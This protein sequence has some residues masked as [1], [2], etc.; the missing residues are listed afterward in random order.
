MDAA[1]FGLIVA[2][3]IAE[4]FDLR[5]PPRAGGLAIL[6]S[7]TLTTG[8]NVSNT[9]VA[10]AKL[11]AKV[12]AAGMVGDDVLGRAVVE[13]LKSA[14]LDTSAIFVSQ[15]AQT[16]A[17]VVA[18]EPGGERCFFHTPGVTPQL[19]LDVFRKCFPIFGKCAWMQVGYFGLLPGLT[20]DLAEA[21]KEFKSISPGTK[22]A[23]DT[24]N[25]PA[26][27]KLLWPI[28]PHL[29]LFAPSRTEAAALTGESDP[30]KMVAAFRP[31]MPQGVIG[32]KLD[33]EGCYLDNGEEAV[34]APAY[35]IKVV[36]TTGAG[37]T[38]FGALLVALRKQMPLK[39]A[40]QFANRAAADCCTALG[41]STGVKN[42]QETLSRI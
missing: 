9:G 5:N 26:D 33:A 19:D 31:R 11:G 20:P 7:I 2:D 6:N 39:Q 14:G 1:I 25:P 4:P 22:I 41:A 21:L 15:S 8:G 42:F 37:D 10:M 13:R 23:L 32:I 34:F 3:L 17:T 18:V 12:A 29:D 30:K 36:D 38:W 40:A 28:L 16:S 27:A 35:K 24:V